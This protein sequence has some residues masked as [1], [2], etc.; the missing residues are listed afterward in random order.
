MPEL[1]TAQ[2]VNSLQARSSRYVVSD[3]K[4]PGLAVMV[5]PSGSKSFVY[6]YRMPKC[7]TIKSAP[8]AQTD[9]LTVKA[10]REAAKSMAADI[11]KDVDPQRERKTKARQEKE[12]KKHVDLRLFNYISKYYAPYAKQHSV[13]ADEIVKALRQEFAFLKGKRI[14]KID[15]RDIDKWRTKRARDGI[16][17]ERI[18]RLYTY[19]KAC[20]NTAVK[21]YKL[22]DRFELQTY[23]LKR[24]RTERVNPP[25][26][27]YLLKEE[28]QRLRQVLDARDQAL[29]EKRQRYVEWQAM[30]NSNKKKL[31]P[32]SDDD[33][34]DHITPI[35]ILAY[36]TGFDLG[37]IFDLD[38]Q[39]HVDFRNNQ[40]RKVRN[41]TKH[42]SD[43]PQPVVVPMSTKV[44][45]VLQQWKRQ[46]GASGRVFQSPITGGRLDNIQSAW[47]T[48]C[49]DAELGDFRFKD[50]RHTFGSWLAIGGKDLLDIRDLMG[51]TDVKTTQVYAHLCPKSKENAMRDVFG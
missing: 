12:K 43:N 5:Y 50:F 33:Y 22:I 19:L 23:S 40:I 35:I 21:H 26:L 7:R 14:D 36:Q 20:I 47:K 48:V 17:F 45:K 34:P 51:H 46:H 16:S 38:W 9:K 31:L 6:R 25:K 27:R 41:K 2:L 37:D 30:R 15:G 49:A 3:T 18:K 4:V 32:F 1:L 24:R 13:S 44:R 11:A 8:I 28:E 29:R 42:K 10:A 39:E